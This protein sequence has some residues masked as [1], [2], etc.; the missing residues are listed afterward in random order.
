VKEV[1]GILLGF[2]VKF[3][4]VYPCLDTIGRMARC[5]RSTVLRA[6]EWLMRFGFVKRFRRLIRQRGVWGVR[7]RQDSNAYSVGHPTGLGGMAQKVF[8]RIHRGSIA[9]VVAVECQNSTASCSK[10]KASKKE[11]TKEQVGAFVGVPIRPREVD[12]RAQT[13]QLVEKAT[14]RLAVNRQ[15]A[16]GRAS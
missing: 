10:G 1:L 6:I 2:A 7:V 5:S 11:A 3:G 16:W 12:W 4:K 14:N 13:R 15:I 8:G 9:K